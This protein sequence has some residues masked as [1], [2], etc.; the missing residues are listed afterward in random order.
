MA[1]IST[2]GSRGMGYHACHIHI[3]YLIVIVNMLCMN[4][5][6]AYDEMMSW[7][8]SNNST[9][10]QLAADAYCNSDAPNDVKLQKYFKGMD[11]IYKGEDEGTCLAVHKQCGW[12][13]QPSNLPLFVLSVG[14]EGA[15][16]HLWTEILEQPV[17]DCVWING[18]HYERDVADGVPRA[19]VEKQIAG[20][21]EQLKMRLETGKKACKS[22]YDAEDSFP[23]GAIRKAGR[24]F[25]RPDIVNLQQLDGKM[26]N[27]KYLIIVRNTTVSGNLTLTEFLCVFVS[28]GI[29]YIHGLTVKSN[30]L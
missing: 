19:T 2:M 13:A 3:L 20:F 29:L 4:G 16:H 14:L 23:T 25:M 30:Y 7:G 10:R 22:I 26:F 1:G 21:K 15:G 6:M 8:G 18:R 17:F 24:V 5:C 9:Q 28:I 27:M 12:P 11:R